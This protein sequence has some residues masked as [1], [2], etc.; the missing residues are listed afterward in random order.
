MTT[1]SVERGVKAISH[2]GL[3]VNQL[4]CTSQTTQQ[5]HIKIPSQA[6]KRCT[7]KTT[8]KGV[9]TPHPL[10]RSNDGTSVWKLCNNPIMWD[11]SHF[12]LRGGDRGIQF[13]SPSLRGWF[14]ATLIVSPLDLS[15]ELLTGA[16]HPKIHI[17]NKKA[18]LMVTV[19]QFSYAV[20]FRAITQQI[21][22]T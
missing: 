21:G 6:H 3:A 10:L 2:T 9:G 8:A 12:A 5:K 20:L 11:Y 15:T 19:G 14:D 4:W 18:W 22:V 17:N 16:A 13:Y 1:A 7:S